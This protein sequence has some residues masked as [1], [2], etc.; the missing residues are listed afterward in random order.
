MNLIDCKLA[1]T[2]SDVITFDG[3]SASGKSTVAFLFSQKIGYQFIDTGAIYRAGSLEALEKNIPLDDETKLSEIFRNMDIEF[4]TQDGEQKIFLDGADI[5]DKLHLP[6]VTKAVPIVATFSKVREF[7]NTIQRE[8]GEKQ[9]TVMTGRDIGSEIFPDAKLKFFL[10]ASADVRARR[11]FE[12]LRAKNPEIK[13]EDILKET[14]DRDEKDSTREVSP[15]RI[16]DGAVVVDTSN[17]NTK[18][19]VDE[20]L[21]HYKN[22]HR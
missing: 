1:K 18:Q 9:N 13:Y 11:R 16:P 6:G 15:L 20:L 2:M 7:A 3:P 12:Q 17:L 19:A 22:H 5:T 21:K 10:T 8:V 4:K 14:Q